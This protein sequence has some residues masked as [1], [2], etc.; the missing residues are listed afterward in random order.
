MCVCIDNI[1]K[2][3]TGRGSR[4]RGVVLSDV[5]CVQGG[6]PDLTVS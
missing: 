6:T 4:G 3:C 1:Y 5:L 2:L